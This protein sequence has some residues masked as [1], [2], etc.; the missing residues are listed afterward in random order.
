MDVLTSMLDPSHVLTAHEADEWGDP[1]T[2]GAALAMLQQLCPFHNL[3][4]GRAYPPVLVTAGGQDVR[5]PLWGP[6]KYVAK[7]RACTQPVQPPA[8]QLPQ[9]GSAAVIPAEQAQHSVVQPSRQVLLDVCEGEG[10]FSRQRGY[11]DAQGLAF[12]VSCIES[13]EAPA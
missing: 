3:R 6:H 10:H 9:A 12:L 8:A 1:S 7:L 11:Q 2:D 5:V 13:I 4:P